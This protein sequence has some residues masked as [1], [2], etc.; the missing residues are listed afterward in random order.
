MQ[1][2]LGD[3]DPRLDHSP[4]A[5]IPV[6]NQPARMVIT[7]DGRTVYTVNAADNT[8]TPIRVSTN[9]ARPPIPVGGFPNSAAITPDGKTLYVGNFNDATVTPI[10]VPTNTAGPPIPVGKDPLRSSSPRM[11]RRP[12]SPTETATPSRPSAP[13]PTRLCPQ[14]QWATSPSIWRS[15][16]MDGR[17]T[18]ST[19]VAT[20]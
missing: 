5:D 11:A 16:P 20:A 12:T 13:P 14:S 17:S 9:T 6:G 19:L 7:P 15:P 1:R 3:A 2:Q 8:V 4:F 10:H 18:S